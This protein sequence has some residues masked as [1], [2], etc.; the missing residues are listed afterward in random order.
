[1]GRLALT[2]IEER[3]QERRLTRH[4]HQKEQTI[5]GISDQLLDGFELVLIGGSCE[6]DRY[7]TVGRPLGIVVL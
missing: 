3:I 5:P 4:E 7:R 2:S 1:M 6:R